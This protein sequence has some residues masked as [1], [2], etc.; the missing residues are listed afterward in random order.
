[1]LFNSKRLFYFV[2]FFL[3]LKLEIWEKSHNVWSSI[4]SIA[5]RL[6]I[7][8]ICVLG[9]SL[10]SASITH[11]AEETPGRSQVTS[12]RSRDDG[13]RLQSTWEGFW[14]GPNPLWRQQRAL[15]PRTQPKMS[16]WLWK[17]RQ[18]QGGGTCRWV[19]TLLRTS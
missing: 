14:R 11:N 18:P 19:Q 2:P 15:L 7:I 10:G 16:L 4:T 17:R 8:H 9:E 3:P 5:T 12:L 6:Q 1:M 13:K